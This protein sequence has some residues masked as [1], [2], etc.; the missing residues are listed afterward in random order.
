MRDDRQDF[1]GIEYYEVLFNNQLAGMAKMFVG[2]EYHG[3]SIPLDNL[4]V[5]TA[6]SD[7]QD[8]RNFRKTLKEPH[9]FDQ[10]PDENGQILPKNAMFHASHQDVMQ[11]LKE[12]YGLEPHKLQMFDYTSSG[13]VLHA[14][15]EDGSFFGELGK[16]DFLESI[17]TGDKNPEENM[18]LLSLRATKSEHFFELLDMIKTSMQEA[19]V[20]ALPLIYHDNQSMC[21]RFLMPETVANH[22][23][24][25]SRKSQ[26]KIRHNYEPL[27]DRRSAERD[28]VPGEVLESHTASPGS[29]IEKPAITSMA[30]GLPALDA[31]SMG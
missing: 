9:K 29:T 23:I 17:S 8:Y 26:Q 3:T 21:M 20:S 12:K 19:G 25:K 30:L 5:F 6:E 16:P 28:A 22:F 31:R 13:E 24:D 4:L 10:F 14:P 2:T 15:S 11:C 18:A 7:I 27:T 1:K